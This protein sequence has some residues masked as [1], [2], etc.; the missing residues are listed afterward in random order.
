M[1]IHLQLLLRQESLM[2]RRKVDF[3]HSKFLS[4]IIQ[5]KRLIYQ[6]IVDIGYHN[7][8]GDFRFR[9]SRLFS[10]KRIIF[11]F[12]FYWLFLKPKYWFGR[13]LHFFRLR[14]QETPFDF[15]FMSGMLPTMQC[16]KRYDDP[17]LNK[18]S[19]RTHPPGNL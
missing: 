12:L 17:D 4:G 5:G 18:S 7:Y 10:L 13:Y 15:R 1:N 8:T 3:V 9:A 16:L 2:L 14:C 11:R 6:Y 19:I